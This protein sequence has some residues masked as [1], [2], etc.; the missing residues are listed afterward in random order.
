MLGLDGDLGAVA[1]AL[2]YKLFLVWLQQEETS[3]FKLSICLNEVATCA[4]RHFH[5]DADI[6]KT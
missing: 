1:L 5:S 2:G 4:L 3:F 6:R